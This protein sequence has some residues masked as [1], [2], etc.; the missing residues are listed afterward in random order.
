MELSRIWI[1]LQTLK[2][3][4]NKRNTNITKRIT[5]IAL[6]SLDLKIFSLTFAILEPKSLFHLRSFL[7][8]YLWRKS[9]AIFVK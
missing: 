1:L 9:I 4:S 2:S 5:N 6:K 8:D 3:E 7:F